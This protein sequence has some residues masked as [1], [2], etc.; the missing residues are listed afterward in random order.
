MIPNHHKGFEKLRGTANYGSWKFQ[1]KLQLIRDGLWDFI[2]DDTLAA[3]DSGK[4]QMAYA[5]IGLSVMP[6]CLPHVKTAKTAAE[7]WKNLRIA[8][9]SVGMNR[10]IQLKRKLH[11]LRYYRNSSMDHY[12]GNIISTVQELKE[13]GVVIEDE[14][15]AELMLVGLPPDFSSLIAI[16]EATNTKLTSAY[17]KSVLMQSSFQGNIVVP[18]QSQQQA[19]SANV[20]NRCVRCNEEGH[21]V[22]TCP[23][24]R[25]RFRTRAG[26]NKC[27]RCGKAGHQR[28]NCPWNKEARNG[29]INCNEISRNFRGGDIPSNLLTGPAIITNEPHNV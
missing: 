15:L 25:I 16:L 11:S 4:D 6:I 22:D 26:K 20:Q 17:V 10:R 5:E 19:N 28:N 27:T 2:V 7:A 21:G 24:P 1:I 29:S 8:Y 14:E 13:I 23:F 18:P 12:V 3:T 9:E